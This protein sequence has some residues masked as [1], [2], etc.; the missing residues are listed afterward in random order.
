M[1]SVVVQKFMEVYGT[2][3]TNSKPS[4]IQ[5]DS[6]SSGMSSLICNPE[7]TPAATFRLGTQIADRS[8][9]E[10]LNSNRPLFALVSLTPSTNQMSSH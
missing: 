10:F 8:S 6:I 2:S 4:Q 3:Q 9:W 7:F 1:S 5:L